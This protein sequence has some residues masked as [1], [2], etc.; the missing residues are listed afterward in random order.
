MRHQYVSLKITSIATEKWWLG[1]GPVLVKAYFQ[2]QAV[3][4]REY[5]SSSHALQLVGFC[6]FN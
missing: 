6:D 3:S 1:D 5:K 4:F 2:G